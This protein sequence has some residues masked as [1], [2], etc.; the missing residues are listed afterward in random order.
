MDQVQR[1]V[2]IDAPVEHVW[3]LITEPEHIREWYAFDGATVDLRLDGEIEHRWD[4]HGRFRG[5]IDVLEAPNRLGYRYSNVPDALPAAGTATH[6]LFELT[7]VDEQRTHLR[8]TESGISTLAL[9]DEQRA[10]Y[11]EAT[12]QGWDGGLPTLVAY[13]HKLLV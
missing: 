6:V 11:L 12:T 9:T 7:P 2:E 3:T 13:A 10:A 8:V 4:E 1:T 5:V